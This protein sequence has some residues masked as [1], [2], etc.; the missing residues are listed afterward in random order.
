MRQPVYYY[1]RRRFRPLHFVALVVIVAALAAGGFSWWLFRQGGGGLLRPAK[2]LPPQPP[3]EWAAFERTPGPPGAMLVS[4]GAHEFA[5]RAEM[6]CSPLS[7]Q[8][9]QI[10]LRTGALYLPVVVVRFASFPPPAGIGGELLVT[11]RNGPALASSRG[12]AELAIH[13]PAPPAQP[14]ANVLAGTL[15]GTFRGAGGSG[16]IEA[17]LR[18]C[19]TVVTGPLPSWGQPHH[20]GA[21]AADTDGEQ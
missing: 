17:R 18:G 10:S 16:E 13:L 2:R 15:R 19:A 14:Q 8:G 7:P 21:H 5:G 12:S 1:R 4:H 9:L 3:A 11:G 6:I 20:L